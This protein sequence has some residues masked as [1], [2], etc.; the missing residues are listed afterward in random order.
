MRLRRSVLGRGGNPTL[1]RLVSR[2]L[3]FGCVTLERSVDGGH[4]CI[5]AGIYQ[6]HWAIHHPNGPHP[7]R[8]P[9][10]DT[11]AIGRTCI[12][13]HIA[14]KVEE[15]LGCIAVGD[16]FDGDAIDHSY[17]AFQRM[18]DYLEGVETWPLEIFDP[19][20]GAA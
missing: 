12:Q 19:P 15:L 5:P 9:E 7:Y 16:S 6:V 8:C 2:E 18:M 14:N 3:R 4:P 20:R 1:G 10:L 13:M 17:D 11:S